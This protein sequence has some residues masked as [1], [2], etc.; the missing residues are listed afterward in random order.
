MQ[1]HKGNTKSLIKSL[2]AIS[3]STLSVSAMLT[4]AIGTPSCM[5]QI[6]ADLYSNAEVR[7]SGQPVEGLEALDTMLL[8]FVKQHR[9]PGASFAVARKGKVVYARGFGFANIARKQMVS[10][11]TRFRIASLAKPITAA[12]ILT[13][14]R[15][16]KLVLDARFVDTLGPIERPELDAQVSTVTIEQLL[17]HRGGWDR[18]IS[19]DPMFRAIL[20]GKSFGDQGPA[21]IAQ[22]VEY[23]LRQ[24]LDFKPGERFAYSNFG[25]CLLGRV[26]EACS[27]Q[28][29]EHYVQQAVF[30][31][32]GVSSTQL[33]QSVSTADSE[34]TYYTH[35][36][37]LVDGVAPGVVGKKVPRQYGGWIVENMD[38]HGGWIATAEDLVRFAA[39]FD[40]SN[41]L[42]SNELVTGAFTPLPDEQDI[43]VFYGHGWSVQQLD[44]ARQNTWHTGALA[45]TSTLLVRRHDGL[46]WAVLFNARHSHSGKQ[47]A[48]L[49]D[50]LIHKA[51][52]Q[53]TTWPVGR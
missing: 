50:P 12:A 6:P 22:T 2:T 49:V 25:Y 36:T 44:N 11:T 35:E 13:L 48:T 16:G 10:P 28:S 14:V 26:I 4:S 52:D 8:E 29:Y 31:P 37:D 3:I 7:I 42:L 27:K 20:I 34:T 32:L 46:N 33:A 53:V 9:V 39:A 43:P 18:A 30:E 23:M 51:V 45:G 47:L 38:A 17:R 21:N 15:D 5:A 19:F 40:A 41:P 1:R 24:P